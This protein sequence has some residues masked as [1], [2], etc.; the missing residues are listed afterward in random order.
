MNIVSGVAHAVTRAAD[1]TTA[2]A[3]AIGGATINGVVGGIKGTSAGIRDGLSQGS[4]SS[5]AAALTLAAVGAAGLVE[6]PILL[7]A[8]GAALVVHELSSR[9]RAGNTEQRSTAPRRSPGPKATK[10]PARK[11]TTRRTAK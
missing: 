7:T 4:G 9:T 11:P 10:A 6:W 5:A 1:A 2:T 3:G 8:G